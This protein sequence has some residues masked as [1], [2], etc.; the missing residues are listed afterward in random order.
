MTTEASLKALLMRLLSPVLLTLV[1]LPVN[2]SELR[3]SVDG[4]R[5][6]HGSVLIG[7]YDSFSSFNRAIALSDKDGFLNDPNRFAAVALRANAAMKSAVVFTNLAPGQYAIIL[8]H[9]ENGN[10]KLDKNAFGVPTEPY[11]FSNN[12]QGFLGPPAFEK[13]MMQIGTSNKDVHIA[14]VFH[15]ASGASGG[16][17]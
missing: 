2:A 7:L 6:Q 17:P 3:I 4:I 13:A 15:G 14:L 12:A 1:A 5:S 16:N 11:G 9:D 8:F 10:G